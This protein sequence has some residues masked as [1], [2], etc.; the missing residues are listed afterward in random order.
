MVEVI[1]GATYIGKVNKERFKVVSIQKDK[2][3]VTESVMIESQT[4]GKTFEHGLDAFKRCL[5]E[6][7]E[8]VST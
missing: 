6:L 7:E 1:V 3:T 4:T 2:F 5:V 8:V